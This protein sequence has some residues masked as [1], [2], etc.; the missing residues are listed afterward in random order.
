[1]H[2]IC[3]PLFLIYLENLN[4]PM[5]EID[6]FIADNA[7]EYGEIQHKFLEFAARK[8]GGVIIKDGMQQELS[9]Y[10][11]NKFKAYREAAAK[12]LAKHEQELA[13]LAAIADD[14]R[15]AQETKNFLR[16][17]KV[18]QEEFCANL[19]DAY[20]QIGVKRTCNDTIIPP[21]P[22]SNYY[23]IQIDTVGWKNLDVYVSEATKTRES[24]TYTDPTSGKTATVTYKEVSISIADEQQFDKVFVYLLPNDLT[25]FQRVEE[26]ENAFKEKL[27]MLFKYDA[28]AIG[29]KGEQAYFYK[30]TNLQPGQHVFR[31][32]AIA[33]KELK[34]VLKANTKDKSDEL[35]NEYEFQLFEQQ[36]IRR[37]VQLEKELDFRN[38]V[39]RAIW[40]CGEAKFARDELVAPVADP[41]TTTTK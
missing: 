12:T 31:L 40:N 19:T 26:S 14:K 27:N 29:F 22:P 11:G 2:S 7:A 33:E 8:N 1:M 18:F 9:V 4:K 20:R 39:M 10:F 3:S 36:E 17:G 21:P 16:R 23:K 35:F 38:Q 28:I 5:Y 37:E 6:Q 34:Q 32:S 30:Q 13:R 41:I 25:S 15:R 24:M